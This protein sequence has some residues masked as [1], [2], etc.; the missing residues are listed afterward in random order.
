MVR[1]VPMARVTRTEPIWVLGGPYGELGLERAWAIALLA[2]T[3]VAAA[4]VITAYTE[5]HPIK[6]IKITIRNIRSDNS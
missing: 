2:I 6:A 3:V 5:Q 1:G 4:M